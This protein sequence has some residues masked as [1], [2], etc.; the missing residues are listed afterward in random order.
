MR[1]S[2]L[3]F[4]KIGL[5]IERLFELMTNSA[6]KFDVR[7]RKPSRLLIEIFVSLF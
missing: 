5:M 1:I 7:F 6:R 2:V 4:K 3:I